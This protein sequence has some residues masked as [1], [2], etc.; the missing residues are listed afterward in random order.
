MLRRYRYINDAL[1]SSGAMAGEPPHVYRKAHE[2][3]S[4]G[5]KSAT[6]EL[7]ENADLWRTFDRLAQRHDI[8]LVW[9]RG[10]NGNQLN[11]AA[12][13]LAREAAMAQAA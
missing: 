10:H 2:Q 11:E 1:T 5:R 3:A 9:V 13:R 4:E 6:R 7:V 12:D 8:E